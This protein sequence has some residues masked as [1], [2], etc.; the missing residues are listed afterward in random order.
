MAFGFYSGGI[1]TQNMWVHF[2]LIPHSHCC[3]LEYQ[4]QVGGKEVVERVNEAPIGNVSFEKYEDHI[5]FLH[6][7]LSLFFC[8]GQCPHV[9]KIRHLG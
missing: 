9:P 5:G 2:N 3:N 4:M 6:G 1:G 7:I 8:V